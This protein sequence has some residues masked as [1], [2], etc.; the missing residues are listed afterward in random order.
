VGAALFP[1][2]SCLFLLGRSLDTLNLIENIVII[3]LLWLDSC[4]VE[5]TLRTV[6]RIYHKR[7]F[8]VGGYTLGIIVQKMIYMFLTLNLTDEQV[9][10]AEPVDI[11]L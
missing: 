6:E 3:S 7:Q 4:T 2:T 9:F 5:T 1:G 11:F 8:L 10:S